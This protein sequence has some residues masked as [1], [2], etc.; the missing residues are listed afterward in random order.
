[1]EVKIS[2]D[3]ETD[4]CSRKEDIFFHFTGF[5]IYG[6]VRVMEYYQGFIQRWGGS[7]L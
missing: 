3:G 6:Q 2:I 1:M 4:I 5:T 7:P